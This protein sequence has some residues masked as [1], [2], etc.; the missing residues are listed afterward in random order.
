MAFAFLAPFLM[1]YF[2]VPLA[3]VGLLLIWALP[4]VLNPPVAFLE[5]FLFSFLI[6]LIAWP[7]YLALALPG[8]PWITIQRLTGFPLSILLL[9]C[10][11]S[12]Q[13]FRDQLG[14]TLK[15]T[16][17]LPKFLAAFVVVQVLTI[18][19][20]HHPN[21]SLDQVFVAQISWT[22]VFFVSAYVFLKPGRVTLM[23]AF[24]WALAIFVCVVGVLEWL[25]SRV[26]WSGHIPHFL[27]IEDPAVLR[28]LAGSRRSADGIYRVVSTF[29]TALGLGEYL[30]LIMPFVLQFIVGRY[31]FSV[32]LAAALSTPFIMFIVLVT[33]SRLGFIGCLISF[34]LYVG[35]WAVLRWRR[36]KGGLIAPAV[37]LSYPVFFAL[38]VASTFVSHQIRAKVWGNGPQAASDEGRKIQWAMGIPKILGHPQGHGAGTSG[39]ILGYIT[40]TGVNTVDS[41]YLTIALDYGFLGIITYYGFVT[42]A[43][44]IAG[45]EALIPHGR[46][47]DYD[48]LAPIAIA[49]VNFMVI[50]SVFSQTENHPVIYMLVGALAA[51]V[52]RIRTDER[53]A[54]SRPT[55]VAAAPA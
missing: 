6:G 14:A 21:I 35:V 30:A 5:I 20:S 24:L 16:S 15:D 34:T 8:M 18:P 41:F 36:L 44:Y 1:I 28:I 12:S 25:Q 51:I 43:M 47:R 55:V 52:H 11:S 19:F 39:D 10:L 50:K 31:R 17:I 22:A 13:K 4:D 40:E 9:V 37:L 46:D 29:S 45:R 42:A 49:I 53:G 38:A 3:M 23:A 2:A 54:V 27:K 7:N 32:K 33:G 26:L 48:F